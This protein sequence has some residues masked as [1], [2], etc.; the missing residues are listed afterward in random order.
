MSKSENVHS[1]GGGV[2]LRILAGLAG[3]SALGLETSLNVASGIDAPLLVTTLAAPALAAATLLAAEWAWH[4]GQRFRAALVLVAGVM[5]TGTVTINSLHRVAGA[6]EQARATY[7]QAV[8]AEQDLKVERE[9]QL[10][11]AGVYRGLAEDERAKGGCGPQCGYFEQQA[12]DAQ[13]KIA[14]IDAKLAS[15]P[16]VVDDDGDVRLI[17]ELTGYC[18][19]AIQRCK[20]IALPLGL[21][22]GGVFGIGLAFAPCRRKMVKVEEP[23]PTVEVDEDSELRR[24]CRMILDELRSG[25]AVDSQTELADRLGVHRATVSRA[26]RHLEKEGAL[27]RHADGRKVRLRLVA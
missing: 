3:A 10:T 2:A 16:L 18:P 4:Y 17:A 8:S 19:E 20:Q 6:N 21:S 27:R 22:L 23:E 7:T 13:A 1:I 12:R 15:L 26:A 9:T 5:L 25:G 14:E 11:N 24:M